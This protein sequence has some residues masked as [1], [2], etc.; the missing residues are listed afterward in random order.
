MV[1]IIVIT[2]YFWLTYVCHPL[3]S[4]KLDAPTEQYEYILTNVFIKYQQW[5][6]Y[7]HKH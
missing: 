4:S 3:N 7:C 6:L 1:A 5:S 2:T